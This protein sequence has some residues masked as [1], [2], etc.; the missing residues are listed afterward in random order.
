VS[1]MVYPLILTVTG[2]MSIVILLTFVIP[3]SRRY[4]RR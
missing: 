1:A 4:S 2:G 3:G